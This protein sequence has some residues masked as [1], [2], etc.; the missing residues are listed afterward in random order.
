[1]TIMHSGLSPTMR[2]AEVKQETLSALKA[3]IASDALD[4]T[5]MDPPEFNVETIEDFELCR[6]VK[7]KGKL[8]GNYEVLDSSKIL[9][10]SGIAGWETIFLQFRDRETGKHAFHSSVR[11]GIS[12]ILRVL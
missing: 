12:S 8:T 7:D 11:M 2:M 4:V 3:D 5:A 1:M 6:A 10:E 9:R